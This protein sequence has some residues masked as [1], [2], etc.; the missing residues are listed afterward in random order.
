SLQTF[1]TNVF[2]GMFGFKAE[3]YFELADATERAVPQVKF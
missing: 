3:Q 2:A 1:P